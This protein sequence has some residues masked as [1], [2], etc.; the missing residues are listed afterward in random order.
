MGKNLPE[1]CDSGRFSKTMEKLKL[2]PRLEAVASFVDLK[3]S[4][5]DVGTDHGYIPVWLLQNGISGSVIASDLNELPLEKARSTARLYGL[6]PKIQ[7]R[8]CPGLSGIEPA[9][10]DCVIIAGM[11]GE[12]I[13]T[14]LEE[15]GWD[16]N[17]KRL[18][19][20][21]MTKRHE[22]IQ[23]L[24]AAGFH[25][26]GES[27]AEEN[28]NL[29]RILCVEWGRGPLPRPAHLWCGSTLTP[30][31]DKQREKLLRALDGLRRAAEPDLVRIA[32]YEEV[33]EDM[34]DAFD[35]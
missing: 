35:R 21:P 28:G 31:A 34:R 9:E 11:G 13:R 19:L 20:Q 23:W 33:L 24:Y 22:L 4:A 8:L 15:S 32:E 29:Y 27:F 14:I 5:A 17:G 2:G 30:Y 18:V 3:G 12:T 6:A 7:F 26:S 16:F 10:A 25:L 1:P